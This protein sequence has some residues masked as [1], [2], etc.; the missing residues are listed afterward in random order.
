M[1][2][3][4]RVLH[5]EDNPHDAE[6]IRCMLEKEQFQCDLFVVQT[7]AEFA[8]ALSGQRF[9][10]I[11][12]DFGL[13][14]Y[15]GLAALALAQSTQPDVPFILISGTLGE[16]QAVESLKTGATDYV[17]KNRLS[18]LV[19]AV[20]R[21]LLDSR[22]RAE[23]RQAEESMRQSEYK[24][25]H[26]FESLSDA[27]FLVEEQM[28]RIIDTNQQAEKLLGL[29]RT[30]ILGQRLESFSPPARVDE[31]RQW[32]AACHSSGSSSNFETEVA[33]KDGR[34]VPV[35]ISAAPVQLYDAKLMLALYRDITEIKRAEEALRTSEQRFQVALK[36]SSIVVFS[37]DRGLRYSWVHNP[38]QGYPRE[39]MLGKT[40]GELTAEADAGRLTEIKNR[41]L[42]RGLGARE[43][44]QI[45]ER[46]KTFYYDLTVEPLRDAGGTN[47]GITGAAMDITER[48]L[49]EARF[50]RAQR[51][52]SIGALA[53]GIAH[54]LN[55]ILAPVMMSVPMLRWGL[56]PPE[57]EKTLAS[58]E[59]SAQR[60]AEL[61]KQLLTFGRGVEGKRTLVELKHLI[62][63]IVKM[64][65]ETFPKAIT[66]K[67][68]VLPDLWL[69][70]ADAT[71]MH[72]VLLNLCV[73]ARD[74]MPSGGTLSISAENVSLD[75]HQASMTP[76]AHPG[77]YVQ[78]QVADTGTGIPPEI[79]D[80]IFD[81]F[82][83]TKE[84]GKG[85]GLGLSTALGIV[86]SHGGFVDVKSGVDNGSVFNIYLPAAPEKQAPA[87]EA[88]P[89][90]VA[91]G[92]GELVLVVDDEP[93]IL[94]ITQKTLEKHGYKALVA[95]DGVAAM[96]LFA[97]PQNP[98]KVVLT[99]LDMPFMDGVALV[100]A[101]K[102][103]DTN[104]RVIA[105]TGIG[106]EQSLERKTSTLRDLGVQVFLS[107]PYAA[108]TLLKT[109][110]D[111]LRDA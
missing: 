37:Q 95:E 11:L 50:L 56:K 63:D 76:D 33:G 90:P 8:T 102:K 89:A 43:E 2:T 92:Q 14:D 64:A 75:E 9:D 27:A 104:V 13:V 55:N 23:L 39:E 100:R 30:Q 32:V 87:L 35:H 88:V 22:K 58:I 40:D 59:T 42:E 38:H 94:E 96:V 101:L 83:T 109:L 19:P 82:F 65:R 34:Q 4:L 77:S 46:G 103:V 110:Q 48:K 10:L 1:K 57:F 111:V 25:R 45:T 18:R 68:T 31:Y 20:R 98:I 80:K 61:V 28:G 81:P 86:K 108:P 60:G 91:R 99:D 71:Q 67:S 52:E 44:V 53:S 79:V 74:A 85:T 107:K 70:E 51:L 105:C 47:V 78:L 54:D 41:V 62:K 49:A 106:S 72:Q 21:A 26:L 66:V 73:N 5:L 93:Q 36:N 69:I 17:L 3:P 7:K 97:K 12:S 24:Y 84:I 16:E 15:D 29:T 6:L